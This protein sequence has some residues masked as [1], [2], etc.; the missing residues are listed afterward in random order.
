M[1]T[2]GSFEVSVPPSRVVAYLSNP[3]NLVAANRKGAVIDQSAR[4]S[5]LA[6]GLS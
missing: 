6:R 4:P 5:V 1:R 2:S 3:R